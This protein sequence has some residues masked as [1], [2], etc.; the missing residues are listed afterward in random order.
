LGELLQIL[1]T[2]EDPIP[3][4]VANAEPPAKEGTISVG[5]LD[6]PVKVA[7][8]H[9]AFGDPVGT[10]R[11]RR[12]GEVGDLRWRGRDLDHDMAFES[13]AADEAERL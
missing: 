13:P 10:G 5:S 6:V 2:P 4:I 9:R 12:T 3:A 11:R 7:V 1:E 8:P